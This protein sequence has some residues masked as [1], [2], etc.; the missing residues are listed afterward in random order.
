MFLILLVVGSVATAAA[1]L[2][3]RNE[4]S[5]NLDCTNDLDDHM[6]C[7]FEAQN[8][9]E[10]NLTLVV[11]DD[12][13]RM[14]RCI[15]QTCEST[16]CCC[17]IKMIIVILEYHIATIWKEGE[18][19][20]SK[21]IGINQSIKPKAPTL[22]SVEEV[23]GNFEV[24][25]KTN[26]VEYYQPMFQT[27]V[28]YHKKGDTTMVHTKA[29]PPSLRGKLSIYTIDGRELEPSTTYVVSVKMLCS[30]SNRYS[31]S[32]E[33]MEFT[34][35]A[36]SKILLLALIIVLSIAAVLIS[37]GI[38]VC[39]VKLKTQ[40]W[41]IIS[42]GPNPNLHTMLHC[43]KQLL[44]PESAI[45]SPACVER[46]VPDDNKP[47]MK[48]LLTDSS[49]GSTQE[50]SGNSTESS[51]LSYANTASIDIK[52]GVQEALLKAFPNI[53]PGPHPPAILPTGPNHQRALF[54][55]P[56]NFG[57]IRADDDT[58]SQ[59]TG[60][61]NKTYSILIPN[62]PRQTAADSSEVR[63]QVSLVCD[64]DYHASEGD[65]GTNPNQQ[66]PPCL[67]QIVSSLMPSNMSYQPCNADSGRLLSAEE[68]SLSSCSSGISKTSG[69]AASE[70]EPWT[71]SFDSRVRGQLHGKRDMAVVCDDNPFYN[72]MPG[73]SFELPQVT[74]DYQAFQS[75][76]EQPDSLNPEKCG[77]KEEHLDNGPLDSSTK[78]PSVTSGFMSNAQGGQGFPFGSLISPDPPTMVITESGYQSI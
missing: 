10:Y 5:L 44:M 49:S 70:V 77:E 6:F 47:W 11:E 14:E 57:G 59:S 9:S 46:L 19:V 4:T 52:A 33:E 29:V 42:K 51:S 76:V 37:S 62:C 61:D 53:N 38:F 21:L 15:P 2:G 43:N 23:N 54:S 31:D 45:F 55:I 7:Q 18:S 12:K 40:W 28:L 8:C 3:D 75:L 32:S 41:D 56:D 67:P 24:L 68:C 71:E 64:S 30:E 69:D 74:D 1:V 65:S 73:G 63:T 17:K 60:L 36:S 78:N 72:C 16:K 27:Y 25:W 20:E 35:L 39:Y 50:N 66:V 58:S 13:T 34:T 22:K 26:N 48:E